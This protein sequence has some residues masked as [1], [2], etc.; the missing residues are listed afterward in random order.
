VPA[1]IARSDAARRRGALDVA[2]R[3][4][5]SASRLIDERNLPGWRAEWRYARG[6]QALAMGRPEEA[7]AHLDTLLSSQ[8][9]FQGP[10]RFEVVMRWAEAHTSLRRFDRAWRAFE[11][12]SRL[13]DRW[14]RGF[15]DREQALAALGDRQFDWDRDLGLA[16]MI[17]RF[18]EAGM[19]AEALTMSEWRRLR[20][21]EQVAL[22]QGA[23]RVQV[24]GDRVSRAVAVQAVDSTALDRARLPLLARSRLAAHTAVISYVTGEGNEPTTAFVLTRDTVR[25]VLLTPIDS[26][27]EPMRRLSAFLRAGTV[28]APLVADLSQRLTLPVLAL[29]PDAVRRVIIVPDGELHRLPF[30]ALHDLHGEPLI[31]AF[32]VALAPSIE[33]ALGG[34][35]GVARRPSAASA[36][37]GAPATMAVNAVTGAPWGALPGA[38][39]EV[40][41]IASLLAD[42]E[43]LEGRR[44]TG[45]NIGAAMAR[46]GRV[47]HIATHAISDPA[48]FGNNGLVVER[49]AADDG[50]FSLTELGQRP[51][52]FDLVVL[53]ACSSGDGLL[54]TGQGLNGLVSTALDAGAR[55]VIA[56]RWALNDTAIVPHMVEFYRRLREGHDVVQALNRT[57]RDAYQSGVSPAVWANLE[58]V[59]DPTLM[60]QLPEDRG[61]WARSRRSFTRWWNGVRGG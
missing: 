18:A 61:W 36:V 3:L 20:S 24:E 5:D 22:Q 45:R 19:T 60:V 48:S 29:L 28:P 12:D 49:T 33:L 4:L 57:Q 51:L 6:L 14:R 42:A 40:R 13:F 44:A 39:R 43:R 32:D 37:I 56:T 26:L 46:G 30:V 52:P 50:F 10:K 8:R 1:L 23:L 41:A 38:R 31:A 25:S 11:T 16:T 15:V 17:A 7:V 21:A 53:S 59:G 47:L 35:S 55:G 27:R 9:R 54:L 2:G 34:T 58:F